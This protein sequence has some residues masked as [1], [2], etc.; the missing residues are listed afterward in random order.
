MLRSLAVAVLL[1]SAPV[2]AQGQA[3]GTPLEERLQRVEDQLAI[4]R[5]LIEYSARLDAHDIDGYV[6]LFARD[7]VWQNGELVFTGHDEIRG[8]LEGMY[9]ETPPDFVNT[10]S[11][12]ITTN[13]QVDVDG[14]RATARSRHLLMRRDENGTPTPTLAG[15]YEDQFIRED[16]EW[17]IL[18]RV[19]NPVMPTREE[20]SEQM[21]RRRAGQ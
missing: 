10:E 18:H 2:S 15:L 3:Q 12:H 21:R 1:V 20:W 9:G 6:D 19:D 4:Q 11:Y 5:V 16:G 14:D 7:G 17:K 13:P 8:L